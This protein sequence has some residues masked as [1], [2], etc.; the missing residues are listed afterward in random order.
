[1]FS[2]DG[3]LITT[4]FIFDN[5]EFHFVSITFKWFAS[6]NDDCQNSSVR[7]SI[8]SCWLDTEPPSNREESWD[9][10][11]NLECSGVIETF[12]EVKCTENRLSAL[13]VSLKPC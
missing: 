8:Q 11:E 12:K 5:K 10:V 1:M 2:S 6:S 13:G 7:R 3:L 9:S 4:S